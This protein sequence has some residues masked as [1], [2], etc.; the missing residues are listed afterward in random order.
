MDLIIFA[1]QLRT[2]CDLAPENSQ[3]YYILPKYVN[4]YACQME[5]AKV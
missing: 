3:D 1:P 2:I 4:Q 5:Q